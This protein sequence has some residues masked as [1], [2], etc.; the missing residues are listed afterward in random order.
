MRTMG[1]PGKPVFQYLL[2]VFRGHLA[3]DLPEV[4]SDMLGFHSFQVDCGHGHYVLQR[5]ISS[6][7]RKYHLF[8][9][10]LVFSPP[11]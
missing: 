5:V 3:I 2:E 9:L 10:S 1:G 11:N 6:K 8:G 7:I 4:L